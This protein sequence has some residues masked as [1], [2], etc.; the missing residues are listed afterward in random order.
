MVIDQLSKNLGLPQVTSEQPCTC[1][2]SICTWYVVGVCVHGMWLEYVCM[3]CGS[4]S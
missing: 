1:V 3:V 2:R 4:G